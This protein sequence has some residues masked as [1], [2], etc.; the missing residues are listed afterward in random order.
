MKSP[1]LFLAQLMF[2]ALLLTVC[3]SAFSQKTATWKGGTPGKNDDW[4][5]PTNWKEDRVP[6]EFS[7]VIIP[8]VSSSSFSNPT[9]ASGE[10]EI[11]SIQ[12]HSGAFL[13]IGKGASLTVT[14]QEEHGFLAWG[15]GVLRAGTPPQI[16]AFASK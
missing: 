7:Q 15:E 4:H 6:D 1:A 12:I 9:L 5:C 2:T 11:W 10:V 16:L 13:R 3:T 14:E 8:D